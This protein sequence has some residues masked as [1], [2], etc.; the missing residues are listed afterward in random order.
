MGY[1]RLILQSEDR[2][3]FRLEHEMVESRLLLFTFICSRVR[4]SRASHPTKTYL[5]LSEMLCRLLG[6]KRD[7]ANFKTARRS[8]C[9]A[10]ETIIRCMRQLVA[11]RSASPLCQFKPSGLSSTTRQ[12][13]RDLVG[14][15][16]LHIY[17]KVT[18]TVTLS[19][20][21]ELAV[22]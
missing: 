15:N 17:Q 16:H 5:N 19:R 2:M 12:I 20:R 18:R 14:T 22:R 6:R 7:R 3:H 13:Y 8:R 10:L 11:V 9:A 21:F 4:E 1:I